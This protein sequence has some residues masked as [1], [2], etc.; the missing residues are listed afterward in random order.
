M[1]KGGQ[2]NRQIQCIK[3][4]WADHFKINQIVFVIGK[5]QIEISLIVKLC[6]PLRLPIHLL[7]PLE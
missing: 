2:F 4:I 7:Q 6:L 1:A 5:I 3:T